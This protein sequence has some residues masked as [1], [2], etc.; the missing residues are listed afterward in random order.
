MNSVLLSA[1]SKRQDDREKVKSATRRS[2]RLSAYL[3]M[4]CMIGLACVAEQFVRVLLTDKWLPAVPFI[5]IM[6]IVY[7]FYPIH[8]ANLTAIQAVGRSDLFLILEI[9]KKVVGITGLL[10][11]MWFGVF[12]IAFTMM[13]TT[14]INSFV[15]AF[16][17]KKLLNYSYWEQIKDLL[18]GAGLSS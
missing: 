12:W 6:C 15:N 11:S 1:M 13:I 7:M 17:N 4:P 16:P 8:T 18:P 3:L 2:I 10:I 5:Q 9:V 14:V